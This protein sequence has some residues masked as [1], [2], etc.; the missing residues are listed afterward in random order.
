M[1]AAVATTE[2]HSTAL[3]I[4]SSLKPASVLGIGNAT[5]PLLQSLVHCGVQVGQATS[6][7]QLASLPDAYDLAVYSGSIDQGWSLI[8]GVAGRSHRILFFPTFGAGQDLLMMSALRLFDE[9]GFSPDFATD[10]VFLTGSAV[11]FRRGGAE[12]P[13]SDLPLALELIRLNSIVQE[14]LLR[15]SQIQGRL[16]IRSAT[17]AMLTPPSPPD[18]QAELERQLNE[19]SAT[20]AET[21]EMQQVFAERVEGQVASAPVAD[22]AGAACHPRNHAQSH[23]AHSGVRRRR[24]VAFSG[25][26]AAAQ[27]AKAFHGVGQ[28]HDR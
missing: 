12:L 25:C 10:P 28:W 15:V 8:T 11:L 16:G 24:A 9:A 22:H 4:V 17:P 5:G 14:C 23:L 2:P 7:E 13:A 3:R 6:M 19:L 21:R 26:H 1:V 20:V 27:A 18:R